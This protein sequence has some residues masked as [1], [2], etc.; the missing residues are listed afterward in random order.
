L[1]GGKK[2]GVAA[3]TSYSVFQ[4][5]RQNSLPSSGETE[6]IPSAVK[7]ITWRTPRTVIAIGAE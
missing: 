7:T 2:I 3:L 1:S 4:E 5:L 6:T